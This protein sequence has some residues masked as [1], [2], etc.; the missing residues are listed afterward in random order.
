MSRILRQHWPE[1]LIEATAL[2]IFMLSA[3]FFTALLS[4]PSSP[5]Q[6]AHHDFVRRSLIGLAMGLTAI[7]LIYSPWGQRSGAHLNPALTLAFLR[8]GKIKPADA[9]F[10]V[11]AQIAG[12]I[13]GILLA[14]QLFGGAIMH[15]SVNYVVT[16]PGPG[17]PVPA[18][19]AE[20]AMAGGM[21]LMVLIATNSPRLAPYTGIL[22]GMLVFLFITF[23][24]PISGMSI[25]PARSLGSALP[26]G[27]W[28]G[29]WIY[30]S[31]PVL[32][33]IAA[34]E[35]FTFLKRVPAACPKYFHG[36]RQRCIFCGHPGSL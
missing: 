3:V 30:F 10:Y 12:G 17:G 6:I 23:E 5:L 31:A 36:R 4:H 15:E 32:G 1:Y 13:G 21:M 22:G 14:I 20:M 18:F 34:A 16:V 33:M 8:L 28:T 24:A 29:L 19:V 11:V 27:V 9:V 35:C 26:S 25:N 2:G 7:C